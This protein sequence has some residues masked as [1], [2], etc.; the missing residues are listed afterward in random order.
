ML[1][2]KSSNREIAEE[3]IRN[4]HSELSTFF[5]EIKE[6][7]IEV[8]RQKLL[9]KQ[10]HVDCYDQNYTTPLFI[11]TKNG[12]LNMVSLLKSFFIYEN[13]QILG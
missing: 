2:L 13:V 8:V 12:H 5:D 3:N 4:Y 10:F 11:A 6:N 7:K 9:L 1:V